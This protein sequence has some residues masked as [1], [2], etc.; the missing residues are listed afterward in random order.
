VVLDIASP[1]GRSS[2]EVNGVLA[3]GQGGFILNQYIAKNPEKLVWGMIMGRIGWDSVK[4]GASI[5]TP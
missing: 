1:H 3:W 4:S 5:D 2:G